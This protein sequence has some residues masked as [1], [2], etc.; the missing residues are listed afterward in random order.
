VF[1]NEFLKMFPIAPQF[2]PVRFAQSSILMY[3]NRKCILKEE[4]ICF[5]F[6]T[7]VQKGAL[8]RG[9]ANVPKKLFIGQSTWLLYQNKKKSVSDP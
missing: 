9:M 4:H 2:Y 5:Y 1:P 6:A 8:R 3:I 7:R